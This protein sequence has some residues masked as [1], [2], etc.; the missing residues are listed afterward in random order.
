MSTKQ[1][2]EHYTMIETPLSQTVNNVAAGVAITGGISNSVVAQSLLS[3][4]FTQIANGQFYWQ[5]SDIIT[6]VCSGIVIFNF[7]YARLSERN[8]K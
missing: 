5:L 4:S 1:A 7:V 8:K 2:L 3:A 6:L